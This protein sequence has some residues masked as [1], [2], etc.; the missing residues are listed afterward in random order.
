MR[1]R[2]MMMITANENETAVW[3]LCIQCNETTTSTSLLFNCAPRHYR[4]VSLFPMGKLNRCFVLSLTTSV[5]LTLRGKLF[6]MDILLT[7]PKL[8]ATLD[9]L[10]LASVRGELY[11]SS[12]RK[13]I[14]DLIPPGPMPPLGYAT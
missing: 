4:E 5:L 1:M 6:L 9:S 7:S 11:S 12:P 3:Y 2:M 14:S 8:L 10:R 13:P